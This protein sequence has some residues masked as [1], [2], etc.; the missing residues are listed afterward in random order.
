MSVWTLATIGS[1]GGL[2]LGSSP[3]DM[4]QYFGQPDDT[5]VDGKGR[6]AIMK[7][8][9]IEVHFF[10]EQLWLLSC[11]FGGPPL[12]ESLECRALNLDPGPFSWP[13]EEQPSCE[14]RRKL[15]SRSL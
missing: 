6:L 5:T 9:P 2:R 14:R 15:R 7:Y 12:A 13:I 4:V 3:N 1:H 10:N 11:E 8:K